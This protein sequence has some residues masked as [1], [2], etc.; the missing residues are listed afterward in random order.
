MHM[1]L[2]IQDILTRTVRSFS[3]GN[4]MDVFA[5]LRNTLPYQFSLGS[6]WD[7]ITG[8]WC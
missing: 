1:V 3:V 7:S 6:L 5:Q 8:N 4:I 2:S